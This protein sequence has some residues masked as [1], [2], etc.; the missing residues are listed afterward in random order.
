MSKLSGNSPIFGILSLRKLGALLGVKQPEL[1]ELV[2]SAGSNYKPFAQRRTR[3]QGKW[4]K[5]DNPNE[6]LKQ[7][8]RRIDRRLFAGVEF[9]PTMLGGIKGRHVR[10]N[11]ELHTRKKEILKLDLKNCFPRTS[12]NAVH[13]SF[14]K[15]LACSKPV[16]RALTKLTTFQRSV[17]QGAP[18]SSF[19]ANM[20]LLPLHNS[21]KEFCDD[22]GL[23]FS[24]F[25][26]DITISG[27]GLKEITGDIIR[28]INKHGYTVSTKKTKILSN[29]ESQNVVGYV[30]NREVSV[31]KERYEGIRK[32]IL[33][34]RN[35]KMIPS[36]SLRSIKGKICHVGSVSQRKAEKLAAL[37]ARILPKVVVE[38][39]K[40]KTSESFRVK[41]GRKFRSELMRR[42]GSRP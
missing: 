33:S 17:P 41:S 18:T 27:S 3:G 10:E 1:K 14:R 15:A 26:D 29:T 2:D 7:I 4:R 36:Y 9:P 5:I 32:E 25:V 28:I 12:N 19:V 22:H 8:Q 40:P 39:P 24:L 38:Q 13:R 20:V 35:E 6:K 23:T 11:A 31:G 30:V 42:K 16:A 37:A 34:F 21:L